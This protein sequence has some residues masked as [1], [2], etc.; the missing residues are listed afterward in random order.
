M[1]TT[2][3]RKIVINRSYGKFCLSHTAFL[4]LREMGQRDVLQEV[5]PGAY[6]P[7]AAL[8]QE[9][10]L[11]QCGTRIPRDDQH[12][13]RVVEE[14]GA[15]ADGHCAALKIVEIPSDLQWKIALTDGMEEVSEVH[16]TWK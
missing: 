10:S 1:N 3:T 6:W 12:L 11:N 7:N 8:P 9:P 15:S 2:S 16:R 13:V 5:D 4:R 14:M